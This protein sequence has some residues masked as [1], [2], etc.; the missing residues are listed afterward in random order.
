[1]VEFKYTC[2]FGATCEKHKL[3]ENGEITSTERCRLFIKMTGEDPSTG[4]QIHD[5]RCAYEWI[6]LMLMENSRQQLRTAASVDD[7][8]NEMVKNQEVSLQVLAHQ[9][10]GQ[11]LALM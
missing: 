6:P 11:H 7:F 5:N 3:N 1:M 4:E 10:Q 8:K 2:P 9:L